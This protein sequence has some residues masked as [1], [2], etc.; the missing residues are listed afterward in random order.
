MKIGICAI[1]RNENLYLREWVDY[2]KKLGFDKIIIYDNNNPE[3]E[4]PHQVIGDYIMDGFV[5]VHN[6]R[7]YA[8]RFMVDNVPF[9]MQIEC[10]N[11]CLKEYRKEMDWIAF[12][13]TDEFITISENEP[14]D[15][16]DLFIKYDYAGKG[17]K[18]VL[19]SWYNIGSDGALDYEEGH[20]QDRFKQHTISSQPINL[21]DNWLK[22]IVNTN[23]PD[24]EVSNYKFVWGNPHAIAHIHSCIEDGS[25]VRPNEDGNQNLL[26]DPTHKILYIK[27]YCTKSLWEHLTRRSMRKDNNTQRMFDYKGLNGWSFEH[28]KILDKF[29]EYVDNVE[30]ISVNVKIKRKA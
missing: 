25:M 11:K 20:V 17:A 23:I 8:F 3:G 15:I 16:H 5:D 27:H 6:V 22:A 7:G 19:M 26:K 30:D 9:C 12:I 14:Q 13:D 10:Y 29:T 4:Y 18:Q 21:T 2:H 28:Q 1:I 24:S